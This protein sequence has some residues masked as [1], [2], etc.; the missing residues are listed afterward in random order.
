VQRGTELELL[1]QEGAFRL[2]A[3]TL[4]ADG[5]TPAA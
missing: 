4:H 3:K 5:L 2:L 1:A